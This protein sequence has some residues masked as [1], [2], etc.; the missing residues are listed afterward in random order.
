[1]RTRS[2][3]SLRRASATL[4]VETRWRAVRYA[5]SHSSG[6]SHRSLME[7]RFHRPQRGH[8][9]HRRPRSPSTA[10]RRPT[11]KRLMRSS[12]PSDAWQTMHVVNT[13]HAFT[14]GCR[15]ASA[16]RRWFVAHALLALC[17]YIGRPAG[18]TVIDVRGNFI[19]L[20]DR[21][22]GAYLRRRA[23][24]GRLPRSA[25]R[26]IV[27]GPDCGTRESTPRWHCGAWPT[28]VSRT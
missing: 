16:R 8:T 9:A 14:E 2:V 18:I 22:S 11:E 5:H 3:P 21:R 20:F 23:F 26:A 19:S 6:A 12:T 1:M 17:T 4:S 7:A 10:R 13:G 28:T 25:L 27:C 24:E 15:A